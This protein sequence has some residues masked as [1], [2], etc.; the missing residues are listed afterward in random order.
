MSERLIFVGFGNDPL[1]TLNLA[2]ARR[3][4]DELT[5]ITLPADSSTNDG[6]REALDAIGRVLTTTP[7][8]RAAVAASMLT[9]MSSASTVFA[10]RLRTQLRPV[11][12]GD[13]SDSGQGGPGSGTGAPTSPGPPP[14]AVQ[15]GVSVVSF[16]WGWQISFNETATRWIE[17]I[18][19]SQSAAFGLMAATSAALPPLSIFSA[20]VSAWLATETAVIAA[21]DRGNGIY[22]SMSWIAPGMFI[23]T[24]R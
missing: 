23:P 16:W 20:A 19:G 8:G 17:G 11:D 5:P 21:V 7:E 12:T 15:D 2:A 13:G 1:A 24:P 22:L 4:P 6:E 14:P 18:A 10:S 3:M 9:A